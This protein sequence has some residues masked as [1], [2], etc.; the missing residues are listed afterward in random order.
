MALAA[1]T[2]WEVRTVGLDTNG[3]GFVAG[4]TGTDYSQQNAKNTAGADISTVDAVAAG[5]T[6]ITSATANF[7]TSIVGN[8]IYLAGGSGTITGVWRQVTARPSSTSITIDVLVAASTG[9]TLNIGGALLTISQALTNMTAD[10]R[11]FVK[12]GTY[13]IAATL[14]CSTGGSISG[15][16]HSALIGYSTV[17]TDK[18]MP[19]IQASA[20]S[21]AL[22]TQ[23]GTGFVVRNFILDCNSKTTS[24]GLNQT[25]S[26]T[27]VYNLKII[28]FTV[29]GAIL[30]GGSFFS[31]CEVTGGIVGATYAIDSGN[32]GIIGRCNVHDNV[33]TGIN[34]GQNTKLYSSLITNNTGASSD[35]VA[36]GV[37]VFVDNCTI[38]GSGRDGI[39]SNG[40][41]SVIE[42]KNNLIVGNAGFGINSQGSWPADYPYDGNAYFNNTLGNRGG[43]DN[44]ASYNATLIYVNALDVILSGDPFTNAAGNDFSL[45]STVGAG[46][47]A[48]GAGIPSSF[49]GGS[50]IG[51]LDFGAVQHADPAV[52]SNPAPFQPSLLIRPQ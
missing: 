13:S 1:A 4:A 33:C 34:A 46:A 22:I 20:G 18:G 49:L 12:A 35:G 43:V 26:F 11:I 27:Q 29:K 40:F 24:T 15:G 6:T 17:R 16:P 51:H 3:G 42:W 36:V 39:R 47:A 19:T 5:T 30:Q 32:G 31:D 50:S 41:N 21:F 9:M 25:G 7:G 44:T 48:R 2:V 37:D 45:N 38:Y 14:T 10:N 28:N 23:S 8:I 52:V